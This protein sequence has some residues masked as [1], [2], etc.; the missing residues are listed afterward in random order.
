MANRQARKVIDIEGLVHRDLADEEPAVDLGAQQPGAL[1]RLARLANRPAA[2]AEL[3][4]ERALVDAL[5]ALELAHGDQPL[6]L[7]LHGGNGGTGALR[8]GAQTATP[9]FCAAA[10]R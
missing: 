5:A 10:T 3:E 9:A 1:Q 7:P 4:R 6:E 8:P 2:D